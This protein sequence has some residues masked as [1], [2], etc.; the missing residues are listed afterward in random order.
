MKQLPTVANP[1][2]VRAVLRQYGLFQVITPDQLRGLRTNE[3]DTEAWTRGRGT[4]HTDELDVKTRADRGNA[5][6]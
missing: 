1:I 3:N 2:I 4:P 6:A 5:E